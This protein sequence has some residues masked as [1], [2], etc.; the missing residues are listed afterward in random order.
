MS[1]VSNLYA[2][3]VF[4]EHPIGLWAMDEQIDYISFIN[5][6]S[7]DLQSGW[8]YSD[9]TVSEYI[10]N[11]QQPFKDSIVNLIEFNTFAGQ[12]KE[13][14]FVGPDLENFN[15]LNTQIET[16]TA[17]SY[18]Y[19]DSAY[20][21]SISIGFE[22]TDSASAEIIE[23]TQTY[24]FSIPGKWVFASATDTYPLQSSTFRPVIKIKFKGGA[25]SAEDY[26]IYT[27][28]LSIGQDAANFNSLSL[29]FI[30]QDFTANINVPT[31]S[32]CVNINSYGFTGK[33]GYYLIDQNKMLAQNTGIPLVFGSSN[34][35]RLY[36]DQSLP[37]LILP[38]LGFLNEVGRF[39]DYTVE[40]WLKINA[41]NEEPIRVFGPISSQD[42]LYIE[43]G[44]LTLVIDGKFE[45]HFVGEWGRPMLVQIRISSDNASLVLNGEEVINFLID[46][47]NINL[48]TEYSG[49]D[50]NDWI[51]FYTNTNIHSFEL[52]SVSIY[53]YK[54]ATTMA[55]RRW[56]YG[57]ATASAEE[58][59]SIHN[60]KSTKFDYTFSEYTSNY[61]YP[62]HGSWSQGISDNLGINSNEIYI[63]DYSLPEIFVD[64]KS[65]S[66]LYQDCSEINDE[67][68]KFLTFRPNESWNNLNTY[69]RFSNFNVIKEVNN[70]VYG[71]FSIEDYAETTQT[72]IE[73]TDSV[74]YLRAAII[75]EKILYSFYYNGTLTEIYSSE[76]VSLENKIAVGFNFS[77]LID[78]IGNT[79]LSFLGNPSALNIYVAGN[80][81]GI[82]TF[83]G[84]IYTFGICS[85]YNLKKINSCFNDYGI[86]DNN[87][88]EQLLSHTA[89]YTLI[90]EKEY[91]TFYIDLGV[92]SYWQDYVP[93]SY[94]GA[95]SKNEAGD[96]IYGVDFL[97]FNVA[98][99]SITTIQE[100]QSIVGWSYEELD[101]AFD[102]PIQK[103][104]NELDNF[105]Y[106][107]WDNYQELDNKIVP[108]RFLNTDNNDLKMY[109]GLQFIE[110]E[111]NKTLDQ[112]SE[113]VHLPK[114]KIINFEEI[115]A[116]YDKVCEIVDNS[117]IY[118]PAN[119]DINDLA[120]VTYCEFNVRG[121]YSKPLKLKN[122]QFASRTLN[123]NTFNKIG[124]RFGK[125]VYPY[126]KSGIYY[127][128]S[129]KNP[130]CIYKGSTPYLYTSNSSGIEVRNDLITHIDKGVAVPLNESLASSFSVNAVQLWL[131]YSLDVFP[132]GL[133]PVFEIDYSDDVIQFFAK[134][135][136]QS[137]KY[138]KIFA[139]NKS[140]K[141]INGIAFYL[142]G[143]LVTEPTID[144][145]CWNILSV[146]FPSSINLDNK[147]GYVNLNGPFV[148]NN[149][150][151][152]QTTD[153][154]LI[155]NIITRPWLKVLNDGFNDIYW[156]YWLNNY[157]WNGVL[158]LSSTDRYTTNPK[159]VYASYTGTNK[160]VID[161]EIED[162]G[163]AGTSVRVFSDIE[164][165]P[166]VMN[167]V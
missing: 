143:N 109:V 158:V 36:A 49:S 103:Q 90:P 78:S 20:L 28:G 40:M 8:T 124:T 74:N 34:L 96:D 10:Q 25:V 142:N 140:G 3:K 126:A 131:K 66:D 32:H 86:V 146:S 35:T 128:N 112:Y 53:P 137:G 13:I 154:K 27:N 1:I 97:Q 144:T 14:K 89:S 120:I 88:Q 17:G 161:S 133:M 162:I 51:G 113:I 139:K 94:F 80:K 24:D 104:Y 55:K 30:P 153:L 71:I 57:Q 136:S 117:L 127:N 29:G 163:F 84:K 147:I 9:A 116:W 145:S 106:T 119:I 47:A 102:L 79:M 130:I 108:T 82:N 118:L 132:Y 92:S 56:I 83:T 77:S 37:S 45:S 85:G 59:D 99:P 81:S 166:Y 121:I 111:A 63:P 138:A 101:N 114:S 141:S 134:A 152:Y 46:T 21:V 148:Y 44:F 73:I 39:K 125:N 165:Q 155:Q 67:E 12:F 87:C 91:G 23:K 98:Y 115:S 15:N 26:Q 123:K 76:I 62:K 50:S 61:D 150:S 22:Y 68:E 69:M 160:V 16:L 72:L 33:N 7:R 70:A 60:G 11:I 151:H 164:W 135:T 43:R 54:M 18:F 31:I 107:G 58:I 4:A 38:G 156:E 122:L 65:L 93:L 6:P 5:E 110:D 41:N 157:I 100:N 149:I 2:E 19:T 129:I 167:P 105:L 42:G 159:D 64:T 75:N 95:Y 48:P 52:D